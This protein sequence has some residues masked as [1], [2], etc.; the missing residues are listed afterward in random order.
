[1]K[2]WIDKDGFIY[3]FQILKAAGAIPT[4]KEVSLAI[5]NGQVRVND[6]TC[7]KQREVLKAGDTVIY[8]RLHLMV[9]ERDELGRTEDEILKDTP[10]KGVVHHGKVRGW[11]AGTI[12]T[13]R[14]VEEDLTNLSRKLH[15]VLSASGITISLAESCTG[16]LIQ[17]IITRNSGSSLYFWGGI[18]T[19][20]DDTKIRVLK[21]KPGT[22]KEFGAVSEP[23]AREMA[24]NCRHIFRSDMAV[25]ITGIAGPTGGSAEKPIGTVHIAISY[26]K[27][28]YHQKFHFSGTRDLIRRKSAVSVFKMIIELLNRPRP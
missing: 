7:F 6:E 20:A 4:Y 11:D 19:Y 24:D 1:M 17:E 23:V 21:V 8:K 18:T 2:F 9:F 22:L 15:E 25:S 3:L 13:D 27:E 28:I 10:P 12:R 16:G 26:L 14:Q 5:K